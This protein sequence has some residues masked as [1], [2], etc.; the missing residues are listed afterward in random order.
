MVEDDADCR[1]VL[2]DLLELDGHAV[3]ACGDA[4]S[5]LSRAREATPGLVLVD[6]HLPGRDGTWLVRALASEGPP[7]SAV[8]V[9]LTTGSPDARAVARDLGVRVLEK[10]FDASRLLDLVAALSRPPAAPPR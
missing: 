2:A 8:P 10:P 3:V 4:A 5:A 6:L 7:L 9:V 1:G